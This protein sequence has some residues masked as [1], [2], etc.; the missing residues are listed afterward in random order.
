DA[1]SAL[2][3]AQEAY[4]QLPPDRISP[5]EEFRI[6][7]N[8]AAAGSVFGLAGA[9]AGGTLAADEEIERRNAGMR[10]ARDQAAQQALNRLAAEMEYAGRTLPHNFGHYDVEVAVDS[11]GNSGL[12][13]E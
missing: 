11:V 1:R 12:A 4:H 2:M 8:G 13:G 9:F 7:R 3:A 6:R 5:E 10:E